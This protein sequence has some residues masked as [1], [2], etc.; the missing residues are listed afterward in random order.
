[1]LKELIVEGIIAIFLY[2]GYLNSNKHNKNTMIV[3]DH[4]IEK[5]RGHNMRY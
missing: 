2:T 4:T 5:S 1:M 3:S